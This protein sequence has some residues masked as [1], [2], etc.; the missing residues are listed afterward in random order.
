ML[1]LQYLNVKVSVMKNW[2]QSMQ[3]A[4]NEVNNL[5]RDQIFN[6]TKPTEA[7]L[8][9]LLQLLQR[10]YAGTAKS[11]V[12]C[13]KIAE[14]EKLQKLHVWM[15]MANLMPNKSMLLRQLT[16]LLQT[17]AKLPTLNQLLKVD[18]LQLEWLL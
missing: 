3:F 11:L 18:Y 6:K 8:L 17:Q 5:L 16:K 10:L 13:K 4:S 2:K 9:D 7:I 15:K 14:K 12:I 1:L